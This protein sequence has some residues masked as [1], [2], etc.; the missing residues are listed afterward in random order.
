MVIL[1]SFVLK[2]NFE[3]IEVAMCELCMMW[4]LYTNDLYMFI[5]NSM[6]GNLADSW[7]SLITL[8]QCSN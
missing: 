5:V 7:A 1:C 2:V 3:C 8:F 6:N 4:R